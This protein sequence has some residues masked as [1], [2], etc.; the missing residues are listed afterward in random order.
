LSLRELASK[1]LK[2]RG[3]RFF[4]L[5]SRAEASSLDSNQ[6]RRVLIFDDHPDSLRLLF[7]R[8]LASELPVTSPDRWRALHVLLV[9]SLLCVLL[10]AVVWPL[11]CR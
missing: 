5:V 7:A 1:A 9:V 3:R 11:I 8:R 2:S 4:A 6:L 10:A